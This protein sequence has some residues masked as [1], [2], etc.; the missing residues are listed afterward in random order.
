M[1]RGT[2]GQGTHGAVQIPPTREARHGRGM[3]IESFSCFRCCY[4]G[5]DAPDQERLGAGSGAPGALGVEC[6]CLVTL[7]QLC[8]VRHTFCKLIH[9][10][11]CL[12]R[13]KKSD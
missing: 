12:T 5:A 2:G 7:F 9:T 8:D 3:G 4:G 6:V 10:D 1:L 11:P 13:H